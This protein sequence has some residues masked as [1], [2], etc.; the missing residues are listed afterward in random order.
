MVDCEGCFDSWDTNLKTTMPLAFIHGVA[1][2]PGPDYD[3][4]VETRNSFFS[5]TVLKRILKDSRQKIFNPMWSA[6][7]PNFSKSNPVIP[8]IDFKGEFA[9]FGATSALED[10]EP[11]IFAKDTPKEKILL[12]LAR[13]SFPDVIDKI[14]DETLQHQELAGEPVKQGLAVDAGA[15]ASAYA[16]AHPK[17]AWLSQI[18]DDDEFLDRLEIELE[19]SKA[20]L[21][22]PAAGNGIQAFG[23]L[24]SAWGWIKD[25]ADKVKQK[26]TDV[27]T[28]ALL[29]NI[30]PGLTEKLIHFF[31]DVF[32]YQ[33]YRRDKSNP[34]KIP[35]LI[36]DT[37]EK[38][39]AAT[40]PG[41]KLIVVC[42]SMGGNI[43]YDVLT[44]F[45]PDIKVDEFVTVG[46]QASVF[47]QLDLYVEQI[48]GNMPKKDEGKAPK[49]PGV[50]R[51]MNIFDPQDILSFAFAPEFE[52]VED[53]A[54]ESVGGATSAHGDYFKRIRFY[55]RLVE[56]LA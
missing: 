6:E 33:T 50:G 10:D 28:D 49:P 42:H 47:K 18:A 55:E 3:K 27:P 13:Q 21:P 48:L 36:I 1:N 29:R 41:E 12:T 53:Y 39:R 40:K 52:D 23:A 16:K 44:H 19:A 9:A 45:R 15:V 11:V 54:F 25:G 17:P 2:R 38:A 24:S 32:Y 31:G 22:P 37:L 14:W 26:A 30:R 56:R 20:T 8:P 51:W 35:A 7:I 5:Q 4:A 43:A 46:C 34:G